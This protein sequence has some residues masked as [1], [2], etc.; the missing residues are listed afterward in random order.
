[1]HG[2]GRFGATGDDHAPGAVH[3]TTR[4]IQL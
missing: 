1:V 2:Y 4:G 3:G